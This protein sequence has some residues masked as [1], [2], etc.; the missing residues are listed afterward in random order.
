LKIDNYIQLG[1]EHG[2]QE[3]EQ[4]LKRMA[5][6]LSYRFRADD[7]RARLGQDGFALAF[8]H[9]SK[10]L[11]GQALEM[12]RNEFHDMRFPSN[13]AKSFKATFSAG[14]ADSPSDGRDMQSLMLAANTPLMANRREHATA[15]H[16]IV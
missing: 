6:L 5:Q 3:A 10:E 8:P 16:G 2:R 4:I 11:V 12:L 15:N 7:D 1:Y 14:I 13:V 9:A